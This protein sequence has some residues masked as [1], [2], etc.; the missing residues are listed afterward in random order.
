MRLLENGKDITLDQHFAIAQTLEVSELQA[1]SIDHNPSAINAVNEKACCWCGKVEHFSRDK[2]CPARGKPCQ[3]P[4]F[5]VREDGV[6]K[7][8]NSA[9]YS[10]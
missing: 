1:R 3:D 5:L 7:A 6:F 4:K 8:G 2:S 9:Y 10:Q